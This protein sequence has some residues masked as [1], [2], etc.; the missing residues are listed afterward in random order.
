VTRALAAWLVLFGPI[1]VAQAETT[2]DQPAAINPDRRD[3]TTGTGIVPVGLIQIESG[4]LWEKQMSSRQITVGEV[5]LRV[6]LSDQLELHLG[7]PSYLVDL[8]AGHASGF[9]DAD[10][11]A[12]YKFFHGETLD[13]ALQLTLTLPTGDRAVAEHRFQP[14]AILASTLKISS[15]SELVASVGGIN[16][17]QD[18]QRFAQGFVAASFRMNVTE[19][20]NLFTELYAFNHE[21][22]DGPAHRY[23]A[24]GAVYLVGRDIA[25]DARVGRGI[26]ND[27][28]TTALAS[29]GFS[30][31][32]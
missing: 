12:R 20:V 13:L 17:S 25:L 2:A 7:V 16:A 28:G 23:L 18:G 6:P 9:D 29:L 10:I 31:R 26:H 30:R 8:G 4:V 22:P 14:G 32:F 21:E 27:D 11:E 19:A 5:T 3:F 15:R 1:A 24:I